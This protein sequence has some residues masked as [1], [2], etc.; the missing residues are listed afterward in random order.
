VPFTSSPGQKSDPVFSPDGN[1]IAYSWRGENDDN[2]D[3]YVELMNAA[4]RS[5]DER[6]GGRVLPRV[7]ARRALHR[8]CAR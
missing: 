1:E 4:V 8:L 2:A 3:I 7:V 6:S 5:T